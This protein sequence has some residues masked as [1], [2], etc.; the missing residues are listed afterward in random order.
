MPKYKAQKQQQKKMLHFKRKIE[1]TLQDECLA[2]LNFYLIL[3]H[4]LI[5]NAMQRIILYSIVHNNK[6]STKI[7]KK[8]LIMENQDG[9]AKPIRKITFNFEIHVF[10]LCAP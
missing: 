1:A 3:N 6:P 9:N 4:T 7:K 10:S 8:V 2:V 5:H